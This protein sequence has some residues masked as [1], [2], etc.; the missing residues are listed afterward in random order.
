M[1]PQPVPE[2]ILVTL[3]T[4]PGALLISPITIDPQDRLGLVNINKQYPFYKEGNQF[5]VVS[6]NV[7]VEAP[8]GRL[9]VGQGISGDK[10]L[11]LYNDKK[12]KPIVAGEPLTKNSCYIVYGANTLSTATGYKIVRLVYGPQDQPLYGSMHEA[13]GIQQVLPSGLQDLFSGIARKSRLITKRK[14]NERYYRERSTRD[15][16]DSL[17]QAFIDPAY[18]D[19]AYRSLDMLKDVA[20]ILLHEENYAVL[21]A[22]GV[23]EPQ[24]INVDKLKFWL[25]RHWEEKG[26]AQILRSAVPEELLDDIETIYNRLDRLQDFKKELE[27]ELFKQVYELLVEYDR[28]EVD[29]LPD[30]VLSNL[31]SRV[32]KRLKNA[33]SSIAYVVSQET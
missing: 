24:N 1:E 7:L 18:N 10:A 28:R 25:A 31:Q 29:D 3:P 4:I 11:Q 5:I 9:L 13:Y 8:N 6:G 23:E 17:F 32:V 30:P 22:L 16:I 2:E 27:K 12:C 15:W 26:L 33:V 20:T 14:E 19:L 21:E